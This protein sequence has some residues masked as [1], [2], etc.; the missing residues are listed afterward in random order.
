MIKWLLYVPLQTDK[1]QLKMPEWIHLRKF[2]FQL[3][4]NLQIQQKCLWA[5]KVSFL[6][7]LIHKEWISVFKKHMEKRQFFM[8]YTKSPKISSTKNF[9]HK[10]LSICFKDT[11]IWKVNYISLNTLF[12]LTNNIFLLVEFRMFQDLNQ[13]LFLE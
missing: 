8:I 12:F 9:N 10:H 6:M 1:A 13:H 5:L 3:L 7:S 2:C 11:K 4:P